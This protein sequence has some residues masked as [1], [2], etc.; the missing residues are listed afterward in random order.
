M[1]KKLKKII[2]NMRLCIPAISLCMFLSSCFGNI[3]KN[4]FD[5]TESTKHNQSI[6]HNVRLTINEPVTSKTLDSPDIIVRSSP[7]EIQYLIGSQWSDRLPRMVQLKLIANFENNGKISTIIKPNQGIYPNYQI[8]SIIRAFE[9]DIHHHYAIIEIS[10]KIIDI[11]TGNIIAQKV[12]HV[13]EAFEEDNKLCFIESLNRAFSRI[14]SEII[15]WTVSS[16][17]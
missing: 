8:S 2:K 13:E 7:V 4:I 17:P 3:P 11:N 6:Q 9:I 10:L 5:L 15:N 16:L 1:D 12:F 14:S